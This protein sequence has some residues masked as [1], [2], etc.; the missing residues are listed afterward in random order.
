MQ[1]FDFNQIIDRRQSGAEKWDD[2]KNIFGC[3]DVLPMWVA[4][5]DFPSPP[6]VVSA[7]MSRAS[8]GVYGYPVKGDSY[9]QAA[10]DWVKDRH[11]WTVER[12]W[13]NSTP[14]VVSAMSIA[15]QAFTNPGD[16]VLIQPPVY[17]GFFKAVQ[18]NGRKLV[19]N[20]LSWN[21][22]R[23][24]IDFTDLDAKLA[25]GVKV[26][27]L[28]SPHNPVGRVWTQ[29]E[30]M[31]LGEIC[32]NHGVLVIADEI[33]SD[34][35]FRGH[36]HLPF[37]AL[38]PDFA[39]NSVTCISPSKTFNV[40]GLNTALTIIPDD[41]LRRRYQAVLG[42]MHVE[43]GNIFGIT[44]LEAAYRQGE[45]WLENVLA[46]LEENADL[47]VS[48]FQKLDNG[49]KTIK[50]EATYLA[51]LDCRELGLEVAKVPTFFIHKAKVGLSD[52]RRFGEQGAGFM[53]LNFAC[54][55]E[56]LIQGLERISA[57]LS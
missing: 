6:E 44:A 33:H 39:A 1:R 13:I 23:Y 21:G 29:E 36:N 9:Y 24:V 14:G 20:P 57:A 19:E 49:I 34:L 17:P 42:A 38:S 26:V 48:Y 41:G 47:V 28:C 32:L 40:A 52:G 15:V 46:Y 11:D 43:E 56:V 8:H 25:T 45:S 30:L 16:K 35:V 5:M 7:L 22:D 27:I 55:R 2:C 31:R 12:G 4:D 3:D 54:P 37:A 51:W 53:R 18:N 10:I 50:P